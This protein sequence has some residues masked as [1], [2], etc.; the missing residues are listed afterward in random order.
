VAGY[1]VIR[2][3]NILDVSGHSVLVAEACNGIRYL[4]PLMFMGALIAYV[5]DS[6]GWTRLALPAAA[7]PLAIVANA[8]RVALVGAWPA[9]DAGTPHLLAGTVIFV[10][11]LAV[12]AALLRLL[13][14]KARSH[15]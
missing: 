2:A 4:I 13:P 10:F 6:P 11:C 5:H 7:I 1:G 9:L 3:G 14:R 8:A 15:A 12:L